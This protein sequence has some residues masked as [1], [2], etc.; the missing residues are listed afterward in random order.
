MLKTVTYAY[1][2][3]VEN[4][5]LKATH[6]AIYSLTAMARVCLAGKY[7]QTNKNLAL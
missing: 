5:A 3:D 4:Q 6:Q 2:L 1:A 7:T